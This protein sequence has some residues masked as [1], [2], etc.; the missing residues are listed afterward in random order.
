[1]DKTKIGVLVGSGMGGI[2]AFSA[3]VEALVQKGYK[4]IT[5]FFIPYSITNM[6]SA[7]LAIDTGLMGP[8]YSISTACATANYC[9]FSAANLIRRGEADIMV[10]GGTEAA[11]TA[12]GVSGFIACRALSQRNDEP[13]KASRPWDKNRDGF[14]MGEGSGVLVM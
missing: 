10:A 2:S 4:K 5:P 3:G 6:G 11:I 7:L 13:H 12:T 8:N 1:M 14:V 9:F